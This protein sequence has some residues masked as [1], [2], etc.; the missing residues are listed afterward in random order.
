MKQSVL[1][2]VTK[3]FLLHRA[4]ILNQGLFL[5]GA[6]S[7]AI[8]VRAIL[9]H[10]QHSNWPIVKLPLLLT[11]PASMDPRLVVGKPASSTTSLKSGQDHQTRYYTS[12]QYRL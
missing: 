10:L 5:H 3:Y 12:F 6:G 4:Q 7:M 8:A 1:Q 2:A 9:V 11:D